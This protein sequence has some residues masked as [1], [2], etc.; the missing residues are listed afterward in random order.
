M[1][2]LSLFNDEAQI[3]KIRQR[4]CSRI[5][6]EKKQSTSEESQYT[7]VHRE[8]TVMEVNKREKSLWFH[9][10]INYVVCVPRSPTPAYLSWA[11]NENPSQ[12]NRQ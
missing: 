3:L 8:A 6:G 9:H 10:H 2:S 7:L 11:L 1:I 12:T 5:S 4:R